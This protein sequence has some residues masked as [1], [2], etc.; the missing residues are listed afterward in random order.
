MSDAGKTVEEKERQRKARI[1]LRAAL[2][3]VLFSHHIAQMEGTRGGGSVMCACGAN[4]GGTAACAAYG[5]ML[6]EDFE[7][8]RVISKLS[9][10]VARLEQEKQEQAD[11]ITEYQERENTGLAELCRIKEMHII[12]GTAEISVVGGAAQLFMATMVRFFR[13]SGAEIFCG[14]Q[15]TYQ[16]EPYEL[17][18]RRVNGKTPAQVANEAKAELAASDSRYTTLVAGLPQ[19]LEKFAETQR[20]AC[21]DVVNSPM[22]KQGLS[23]ISLS[24]VVHT[25]PCPGTTTAIE[26]FLK[27]LDSAPAKTDAGE[28]STN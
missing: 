11:L 7:Q 10:Q 16:G 28:S 21:A 12:D 13:E 1:E 26:A 3:S 24:G 27:G 20:A 5:Q 8:K 17:E 2:E 23:S 4:C 14:W 19:L 22:V 9:A 6:S 25:T 15:F 18:M